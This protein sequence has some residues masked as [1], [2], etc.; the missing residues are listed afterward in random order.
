MDYYNKEIECMNREDKKDLQS[1]RLIQTVRRVYDNVKT[2]RE[3]MDKI[4]LKPSDI[5]SIDD[6]H[7]LPFTTKQ[8]LRDNY[9]FGMF[10]TKKSDIIRV[11]ASS[12]T[13]GKLTVVGYTK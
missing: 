4:N 5:K 7:K 9:P 6:I 13:T 10:A 8:D 11:H 1:K 3:K 2:Y 12:G